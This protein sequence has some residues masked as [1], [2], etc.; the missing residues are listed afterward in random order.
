M[1]GVQRSAFSVQRSAF[2]VQRSAFAV[3]TSLTL[4]GQDIVNSVS[5]QF[6]VRFCPSLLRGIKQ[7]NTCPDLSIITPPECCKK[8]RPGT[9]RRSSTSSQLKGDVGKSRVA[10]TRLQRGGVPEGALYQESRYGHPGASDLT[11]SPPFFPYA[12]RLTAAGES[13]G[14]AC[15]PPRWLRGY[16][17]TPTPPPSGN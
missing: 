3:R 16:F 11:T 7:Q 14:R 15:P 17:M 12:R 4:T 2:S 5:F 8:A 10:A 9:L 13:P 1:L 6:S